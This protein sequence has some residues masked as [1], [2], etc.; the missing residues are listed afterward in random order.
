MR[1]DGVVLGEFISGS[2]NINSVGREIA[3]T[4]FAESI[5]GALKKQMYPINLLQLLVL[6]C[7]GLILQ[8]R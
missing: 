2:T 8:R 1:Q 4:N 7:L 6:V 3:Y 5:V